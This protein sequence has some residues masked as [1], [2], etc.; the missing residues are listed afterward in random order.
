MRKKRA[1][2]SASRAEPAARVFQRTQLRKALEHH[3]LGYR[4]AGLHCSS[5]SDEG[6]SIRKTCLS[7]SVSHTSSQRTLRPE[8]RVSPM[9][10]LPTASVIRAFNHPLREMTNPPGLQA[11]LR[12]SDSPL[13]ETKADTWVPPFLL[14]PVIIPST[15]CDLMALIH[16]VPRCCNAH[17]ALHLNMTTAFVTHS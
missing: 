9:K 4:T 14:Q 2:T 3:L 1:S 17:N 15:V 13:F 16:Y 6:L 5:W 11:A 12:R 7:R 10:L 8:L